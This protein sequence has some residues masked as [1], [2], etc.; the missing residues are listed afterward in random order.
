MA[1][2]LRASFE[3]SWL[4][5]KF[6][7]PSWQQMLLMTLSCRLCRPSR[8]PCSPG[9]L[10]SSHLVIVISH[11]ASLTSICGCFVYNRHFDILPAHM[12]GATLLYAIVASRGPTSMV[13][14]CSQHQN[15]CNQLQLAPTTSTSSSNGVE[16]C[17]KYLLCAGL[18]Q[19]LYTGA[20]TR[21]SGLFD[22]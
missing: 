19:H 1:T 6:W 16:R 12:F 22:R 11:S 17:C 18:H 21:P 5:P 7:G 15:S 9:R 13:Q 14:V 20:D 3:I 2:S 8:C 4:P 10:K